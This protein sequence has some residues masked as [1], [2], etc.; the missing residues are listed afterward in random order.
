M[1]YMNRVNWD[2]FRYDSNVD[3]DECLSDIL[4]DI[5]SDI[6]NTLKIFH[7]SNIDQVV[8]AHLN[9]N[10]IRSKFEQLSDMTEGHIDVLMISE[11]KLDNS[12]SDGQFLIERYRAPFW[13]D[14]N[15]LEGDIMFFIRSDIPAKLRSVDFGFESFFDVLNFQK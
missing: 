6:K 7:K 13:L 8:S 9:I 10:S 12:F 11:F 3:D 14:Q 15:K 4:G 2:V 5:N 1:C